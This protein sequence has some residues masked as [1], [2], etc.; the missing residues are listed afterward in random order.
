MENIEDKILNRITE[1]RIKKDVS[2][3]QMSR[4][5]NKISS[6]LSAMIKNKSIPS[7][8]ALVAICDYLGIDLKDF[9][10]FDYA[11]PILVHQITETIK[12]FSD[13]ELQMILDLVSHIQQL[14]QK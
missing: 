12:D 13:E 9:F 5:I 7:F 8:K 14:K 10:D 11:N 4:E 3:K 2:E 1:L 6:Y